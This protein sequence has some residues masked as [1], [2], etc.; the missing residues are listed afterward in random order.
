MVK[1]PLILIP[2]LGIMILKG[3]LW[4]LDLWGPLEDSEQLKQ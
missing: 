1:K 4:L 3:F 2:D